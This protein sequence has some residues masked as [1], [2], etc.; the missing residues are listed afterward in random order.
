M[1]GGGDAM[2]PG[3]SSTGAAK[4]RARMATVSQKQGAQGV[5]GLHGHDSCS[6]QADPLRQGRRARRGSRLLR[7]GRPTC[8][9]A[10]KS[11]HGVG[12]SAAGYGPDGGRRWTTKIRRAGTGA[13]GPRRC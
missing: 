9:T 8:G 4:P 6:G 11:G 1:C 2:E 12:A 5:S 10:G 13:G 7:R 3:R